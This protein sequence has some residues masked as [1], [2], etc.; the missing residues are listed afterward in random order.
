[1]N[2]KFSD[3]FK[4]NFFQDEENLNVFLNSLTKKLKKT[5]RINTSKISVEEL[6]KRMFEQDYIL[7]PTFQKNVFYIEK[8][9]NPD[10]EEKKLGTTLEHLLWYF[11]VQE[12]WAS[13]SVFYLANWEIDKTPHLILDMAASPGWKTTQLSEYYPDSFIVANEFDS[14][15]TKQLIMN[16]E[17]LWATNIWITNYNWQYLGR[18]SNTFDKVLLDAPCSWEWTGFKTL[19]AL[20]F[21]NIKNVKKIS[22]LQKKLFESGL[23]S[24]KVW[25]EMLYS[26]CTMN[27]FENEWVVEYIKEKHPWS[28]E[29][30]FEKRFWPHIDETWWFFVCKIKK[31]KEI[32]YRSSKKEELFNENIKNL[33][34][35]EESIM[36]NFGKEFW[37]NFDNFELLKYS[38]EIIIINKKH[39]YNEISGRIYF[40]K[41]GQRIGKI[42]EWQF[43]PNYYIWRDFWILKI[44]KYEIKTEQELDIYL[45][46]AEIWENLEFIKWK[47]IVWDYVQL[48][49]N[50]VS[51]WLWKISSEWT[52]KNYFPKSWFRK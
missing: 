24:L 10:K 21:W 12:L 18:I 51:V 17:R 14:S 7:T 5:I 3:Y 35:W 50:S 13:S 9:E 25:W 41:L 52:I 8:W 1:M 22:E 45:K 44:P 28:F 26:T 19:E 6:K 48:I 23:N 47:K 32:E 46:W 42:E 2:T 33:T 34:R 38:N 16:I 30:L 20:K 40:F 31:L 37:I 43:V 49:Y 11:Y 15:R 4:E 39:P 29:I 27:E 36:N